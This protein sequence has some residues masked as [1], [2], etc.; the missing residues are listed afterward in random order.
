MGIP[1]MRKDLFQRTEQF[2]SVA[3]KNLLVAAMAEAGQG[4]KEL[5]I[6]NN[7][8]HQGVPSISHNFYYTY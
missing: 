8:Y 7:Q 3:M 5:A 2:L 1:S 4:E 6:F